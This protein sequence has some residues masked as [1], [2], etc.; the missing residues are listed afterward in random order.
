MLLALLPQPRSK[1]HEKRGC[2]EFVPLSRQ[3]AG[4]SK[5]REKQSAAVCHRQTK[6]K[7]EIA[8]G[9]TH[10]HSLRQNY[11]WFKRFHGKKWF[12]AIFE[13]VRLPCNK[14]VSGWRGIQNSVTRTTTFFATSSTCATHG[15]KDQVWWEP[16]KWRYF[17]L[18][19]YSW[20][21]NH[22]KYLAFVSC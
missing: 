22:M 6:V 8:S 18:I 12:W 3:K 11:E 17:C 21:A 14:R 10:K 5:Y 19:N 16:L 7:Q 15:R 1:P 2:W 20:V 13:S 9:S 4:E